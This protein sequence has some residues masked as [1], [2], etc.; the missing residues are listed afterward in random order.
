MRYPDMAHLNTTR[1]GQGAP[2][3]SHGSASV[4]DNELL[5]ETGLRVQW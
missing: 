2:I 4:D 5:T 1:Q 3:K